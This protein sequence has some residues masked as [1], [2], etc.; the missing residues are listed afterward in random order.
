MTHRVDTGELL[1]R[2]AA[3]DVRLTLDGD[4]LNVN[5]PKGALNAELRAELGAAKE[6]LKAHLRAH[7]PA[8]VLEPVALPPLVPIPRS[9]S[10]PVSHTQQRLWFLRQ[11]DPRSSTYNV[12][13]AFHMNGPLDVAALERSLDDLVVRHESLRTRFVAVDGAP[14]CTVEPLARLRLRMVDL[15]TVDAARRDAAAM[16]EV[17]A[18]AREPFDLTSCPLLRVTLVKLKPER[19]L[20]CFVVDHIVADGI[21]VGIFFLELQALYAQ[22]T[23]GAPAQLPTLAVQYV[24]YVH[25]QRQ[26]LEAGALDEHLAHW[27]QQL[28]GFPAVLTLPTGSAASARPDT[29]RGTPARDFPGAARG[30]IEGAGSP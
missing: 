19:H 1:A 6:A 9:A 2:L 8:S 24:D 16:D 10:M 25:W 20:F 21:S 23:T 3:I 7:S 4:R 22:H 12:V 27:K 14:R 5:A 30:S 11:M 15:G 17:L 13:S 29:A 26:V 28:R 18:T